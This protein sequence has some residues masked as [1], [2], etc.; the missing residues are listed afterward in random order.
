[1]RKT[2]KKKSMARPLIQIFFF[3]LVALITVNHYFV[4]S[5]RTLI[6]L[7]SAASLHAICPFGGVVT[8]SEF[9]PQET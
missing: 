3:V 6:R 7:F 1:M 8:L 4:E 9:S 5:G 2:S